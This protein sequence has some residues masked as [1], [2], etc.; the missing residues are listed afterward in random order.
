M[1]NIKNNKILNDL[2]LDSSHSMM[3]DGENDSSSEAP[4]AFKRYGGKHNHV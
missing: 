4:V 1:I 2:A 3:S